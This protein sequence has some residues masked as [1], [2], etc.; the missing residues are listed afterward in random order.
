MSETRDHAPKPRYRVRKQ[1]SGYTFSETFIVMD[2]TT[3]GRVSVHPFRTRESAQANADR[4]NIDDL[5]KDYSADPRPYEVR[6]AE[7]EAAY[8]RQKVVAR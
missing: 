8:R 7:A 2:S 6:H 1:S 3:G 4:L 5:V